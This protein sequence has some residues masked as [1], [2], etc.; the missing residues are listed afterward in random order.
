MSNGIEIV[1]HGNWQKTVNWLSGLK[2]RNYTSVLAKYGEMGVAALQHYTPKDTGL[3]ADSWEYDITYDER[4]V[5]LNW[6]NTNLAR[7]AISIALLIQLGHA[8]R[9]GGFV[10]GVDYINPALKPVFEAIKNDV[11]KEVTR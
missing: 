9:N 5:S 7:D 6:Y 3:T 11:W 8:T 2:K 10:Q 1:S 4:G